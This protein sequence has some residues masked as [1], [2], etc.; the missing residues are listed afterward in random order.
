MLDDPT[1]EDFGSASFVRDHQ[2][3]NKVF[4]EIDCIVFIAINFEHCFLKWK[5]TENIFLSGVKYI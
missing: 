3:Y 1:S 4:V 5:R 2:S